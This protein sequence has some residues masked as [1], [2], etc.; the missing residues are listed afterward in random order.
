MPRWETLGYIGVDSGTVMVVDPCYVVPDA[1]WD[2]W[3]HE[4]KDKDGFDNYFAE[5]ESGG[6]AVNTAHGDGQYAVEARRDNRG[7][8]LEIRIKF[9]WDEE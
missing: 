6:I 4:Y 8:I 5:M 1:D 3:H 9:D 2:A 7:N